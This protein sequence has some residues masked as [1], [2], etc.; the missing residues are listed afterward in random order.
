MVTTMA[1]SLGVIYLYFR[2][3]LY[4][5]QKQPAAKIIKINPSE[6]KSASLRKCG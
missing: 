4:F 5:D 6:K 3:G 1:L 2:L